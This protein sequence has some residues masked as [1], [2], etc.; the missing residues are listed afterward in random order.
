[1]LLLPGFIWHL[2][3]SWRSQGRV[4]GCPQPPTCVPRDMKALT[5]IT[6]GI[7]CGWEDQLKSNCELVKPAEAILTWWHVVPDSSSTSLPLY[8]SESLVLS[9]L[10]QQFRDSIEFYSV[11]ANICSLL[12]SYVILIISQLMALLSWIWILNRILKILKHI[13]G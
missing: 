7:F 8:R 1:M 3:L 9:Y 6:S 11:T 10:E 2:L 12:S 13:N 5:K 4:K